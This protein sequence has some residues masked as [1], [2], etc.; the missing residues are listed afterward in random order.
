MVSVYEIDQEVVEARKTW[1]QQGCNIIESVSDA[2]R[3]SSHMQC[4]RST[5]E[6]KIAA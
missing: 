1:N 2:T 3:I 5:Y 6:L 4:R